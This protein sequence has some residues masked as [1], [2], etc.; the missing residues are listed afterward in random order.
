MVRPLAGLRRPL[1]AILAPALVA[2][3]TVPDADRYRK[4]LATPTHLR[5]LLHHVLSGADSLRQTHAALAATPG[6]WEQLGLPASGI[7]RSQLARS[8]TSRPTA[9]AETLFATVVARVQRGRPD[10]DLTLLHRVQAID[11]TFLRLSAELSPWSTRKRHVP[12]VKVQTG[13]DLGDDLATS[14][15]T[16][17][18]LTGCATQDVP[19]LKARDLAGLAG[20]TVLIDLGFYAHPLFVRLRA[21]DVS[22]VSR[23]HPQASYRVTEERAVDGRA[24]SDGDIVLSDQRIT[25]GSPNN[26]TGAVVPDLRLVTSRNPQ[27]GTPSFVTDRWDLTAAEVVTLYRKRW[28][29]EV[30]FRFLKRQVKLLH[31]FGHS[32][33]AVWLTVLIA[34]TVALLAA[35]TEAERPG[36]VSRVAWLRVLDQALALGRSIPSRV[37]R[38]PT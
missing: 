27:G 24:T 20:W 13:L 8:S 2:A 37:V 18:T 14:L 3:A 21:A 1:R 7:S 33:E 31:P 32:R 23:L 26:R 28:R 29:I 15:P 16:S 19:T 25:L 5:I 10:P 22:F 4:R 36:D 6:A 35:V 34:A 11:S 17:L 38:T 12:G 30:F 9:C